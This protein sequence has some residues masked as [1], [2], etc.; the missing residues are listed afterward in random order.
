MGNPA[1]AGPPGLGA[2]GLGHGRR[3][4]PR[5]ACLPR[6]PAA[7]GLAPQRPRPVPPRAGVRGLRGALPAGL[8]HQ[9]QDLQVSAAGWAGGGG[10]GVARN[11][12]SR[13]EPTPAPPD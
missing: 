12:G 2:G 1:G 3:G 7:P 4:A 6:R 8:H 11:R 13:A 5:A 9:V 10:W